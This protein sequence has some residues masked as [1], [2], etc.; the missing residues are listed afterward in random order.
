MGAC[1]DVADVPVCT[2]FLLLLFLPDILCPTRLEV[3]DNGLLF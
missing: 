1:D 2:R 3:L